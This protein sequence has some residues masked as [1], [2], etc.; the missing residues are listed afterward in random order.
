MMPVRTLAAL[1]PLCLL[2]CAAQAAEGEGSGESSGERSIERSAPAKLAALS[3]VEISSDIT[4]RV[5]AVKVRDG[6]RFARGDLL[7]SFDCTQLHAELESAEA[8]RDLTERQLQ[9]NHSL[10]ELGGN[11]SDLEI[12]QTQAQLAEASARAKILKHRSDHC[13]V[14]AP[15]DG[16]VVRREVEPHQRAEVGTPLFELVDNRGLEVEA[17]VPSAWLK[18]LASGDSFRVRIDETGT[19]YRAILLRIVP[20]V[21]PVTRSVRVIGRIE[22]GGAALIAGMSGEAL[23]SI[24]RR[25]KTGNE[26][27]VAGAV[28]KSTPEK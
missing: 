25:I 13:E 28:A 18:N 26:N 10:Q 6:D 24:E 19:S 16:F 8:Q 4:A 27:R 20:A 5:T 9:S 23:F 22:E 7:A 2:A 11:I 1:I 12:L 17:I 14:R 15:F 21:D 3:R